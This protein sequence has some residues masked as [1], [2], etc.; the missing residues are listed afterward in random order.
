MDTRV[1][2]KF[3]NGRY[4]KLSLMFNKIFKIGTKKIFKI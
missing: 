4:K 2:I 3:I 1:Y